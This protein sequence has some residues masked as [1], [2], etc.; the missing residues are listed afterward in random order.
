MIQI[1]V[2]RLVQVFVSIISMRVMTTLLSPDAVG[3]VAIALSISVMFNLSLVNPIWMYIL[4]KVHAWQRGGLLSRRIL[5][6]FS[7][8]L[9]VVSVLAFLALVAANHFGWRIKNSDGWVFVTVALHFASF[10]VASTIPLLLNNLGKV[11]IAAGLNGGIAVA[12]LAGCIFMIKL[13]G[14]TPSA[15][16]FGLSAGYVAISIVGLPQFIRI[17]R[18][19]A[20]G[21]QE[22]TSRNEDLKNSVRF[23]VPLAVSVLFSWGQ[24][25]GYRFIMADALGTFRLGIFFSGYALGAA[26]V[27]TVENVLIQY[28]QPMFYKRVSVAEPHATAAAWEEYSARV[29]PALFLCVAFV[30]GAAPFL[31]K[32]LLG[33]EFQSAAEF[34]VWGASVEALRAAF[35]VFSLSAHAQTRTRSLMSANALASAT[36][37]GLAFILIQYW[38]EVGVGIALIISFFI[39]IA[40]VYFQLGRGTHMPVKSRTIWDTVVTVVFVSGISL[41]LRMC[42]PGNLS[43]GAAINGLVLLSGAFLVSLGFITRL[44]PA[45]AWRMP[46]H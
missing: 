44:V 26:V 35:A 11:S 31:S 25:H 41:V 20:V 30:A 39:S 15:W 7:W 24:L 33:P 21:Y 2:A 6:A 10:S 34:A 36:A 3:V 46:W 1:S 17:M 38:A 45:I 40:A 29:L 37:G 4:R 27:S 18:E 5:F 28:F 12:S 23:A 13:I 22:D 19:K 32:V 9:L 42:I 14:P 16:L 43:L 8:Y